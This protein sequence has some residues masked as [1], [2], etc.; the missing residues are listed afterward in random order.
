MTAEEFE[1]VADWAEGSTHYLIARLLSNSSLYLE[2]L[3]RCFTYTQAEVGNYAY[4]MGHNESP[5]C[6]NRRL[7]VTYKISEL[8]G[9][10]QII[11]LKK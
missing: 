4:I 9:G 7:S 6:G 2:Q 8:I 5:A 10:K 3:Y 11:S 1:C